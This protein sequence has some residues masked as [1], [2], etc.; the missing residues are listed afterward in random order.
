[1]QREKRL[2]M[3]TGLLLLLT[4]LPLRAEQAIFASGCFWCTESDFEKVEGVSE[5]VS[6]YIGGSVENPSYH[7]VSAGETGHTEAVRVE[8]D[9]AV[10]SYEELLDVYW[11]NV[12]PTTDDRQFCDKGSQ[13]RPGLFPLNDAQETAAQASKQA[14]IEAGKV[15][16]V[17]VEITSGKTFYRA[18]TYH[19]DYYKKNP[20][21]YRYYRYAC[22]RDARLDELWGT[23][24]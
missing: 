24:D 6:G 20:L 11:R 3:V 23:S 17:L 14:V 8:F 7:A 19:Q 5:A 13:Y 9:P 10:V 21:R 1:M 12:D 22:G 15:S 18:E 16:P 2:A 4:A